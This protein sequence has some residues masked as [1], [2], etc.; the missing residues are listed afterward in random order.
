[1]EIEKPLKDLEVTGDEVASSENL[2]TLELVLIF[3]IPTITIL[4]FVVTIVLCCRLK[5]RK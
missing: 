2:T 4:L 3:T 5:K 1:V